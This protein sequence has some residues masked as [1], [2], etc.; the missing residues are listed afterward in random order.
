MKKSYA[1]VHEY[2]RA[3]NHTHIKV[4]VKRLWS[5]AKMHRETLNVIING[6]ETLK[7][8]AGASAVVDRQPAYGKKLENV[9][10]HENKMGANIR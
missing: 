3:M 7:R 4:A 10:S 8:E 1:S 5:E 6:K 2:I 9:R